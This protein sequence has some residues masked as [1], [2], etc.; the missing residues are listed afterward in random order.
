MLLRKEA[1]GGDENTSYKARRQEQRQEYAMQGHSG[2][3]KPQQ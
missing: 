1:Q 3:K 2:S